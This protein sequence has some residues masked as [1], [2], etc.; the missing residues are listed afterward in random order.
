MKESILNLKKS[1]L[2]NDKINSLIDFVNHTHNSV[3]ELHDEN[4]KAFKSITNFMK[5]SA[6]IY[7]MGQSLKAKLKIKS[8]PL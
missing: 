1:E 6:S 5:E 2:T 8:L 4:V 7:K 3:Y